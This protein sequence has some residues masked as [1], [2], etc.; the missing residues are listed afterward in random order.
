MGVLASITEPGNAAE[1]GLTQEQLD[2]LEALIKQHESQALTFASEIRRLPSAERRAKESENIRLIERKGL[3]L[4]TAAQQ[5][6]AEMWRLQKLGPA[7]LVEPEVA[8]LMGVSEEQIS[9]IKNILEGKRILLSQMGATKGA[10]ELNSRIVAVLDD[11]QKT[12]WQTVVG[13]PLQNDSKNEADSSPE[14]AVA[15]TAQSPSDVAAKPLLPMTG[16]ENGLVISFNGTPW[17]EVLQWLAKQAELS[18]QVDAYPTGTFTYRDPFRR[19]SVA[20]TMDIMN[21]VLLGKGY[22]LIKKQRILMSQDLGSGDTAATAELTR[23]LVRELAEL[24]PTAELDKRGDYEIVKCVFTIERSVDEIVKEVKDLIGPQGSVVP[25]PTAGQI[26]V[27]ETG[28]KLRIIR[29]LI[30]KSKSAKIVAIPLKHVSPEEVLGLARP[31]LGLKDSVNTS[32]DLSISP[33]SFNNR[34]LATGSADKLQKLSE[35]AAQIDVA[36]SGDAATATAVEPA[37][38][39][40]HRLLGSDPTTTMDVLQSTFA[41][42]T[43][44]KLSS[45]PKTSNILALAI[46]ADHD[47]IDEIIKELAGQNS[48]FEVIQLTRLDTQSAL[49]LLEKFYGKPSKDAATAKGPVFSGDAAT[50]RI[51][52]KG[53]D[54][55]IEQIKKLLNT[56]EAASPEPETLLDGMLLLPDKG[57][58]ADK[59]LDQIQM[60][61]EAKK[62]KS[63]FR[64]I[65]PAGDSKG[66]KIG[67]PKKDGRSASEIGPAS[68]FAKFVATQEDENPVRSKRVTAAA[69][70]QSETRFGSSNEIVIRR[71]PNGMVVTSDNQEAL[72][73][74]NQL[75]K[76]YREQ[77]NNAATEPTVRVLTHIKAAAA[78]ELIQNIIKGEAATGGGGGGGLIGDVASSV[79]GGGGIFGSLFGG[80][81]AGSSGASST[82]TGAAATGNIVLT[83]DPRLNALWIQANAT[84]MQMVEE[85]IEL[86][87]IADS[88]VDN[89]TRGTPGIIF[90]ENVAVADVETLVK[91][92]FA[93]R[94]AQPATG[95]AQGQ[96]SQQDFFALIAGGR[97]G[98]GGGGGGSAKSELKELTMTVSADKKNN[99]LIVVASPML[100]GE[101]EEFVKKIDQA[102]KDDES[103]FIV[104]P[105]PA[106]VNATTMQNALKSAFGAS[107]KTST[108]SP[109]TPGAG[110]AGAPGAAGSPSDFLQ[111]F[112]NRGAGGGG[113]GGFGGFGGGGQGG[114]GGVGQGGFG[115]AGRGGAQGGGGFG[116]GGFGGG[117]RGGAGGGGGGQGGGGRGGR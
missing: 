95:G 90:I 21:S 65:L 23:T 91:Q 30:E 22:T 79:L 85:L 39:R 4:L 11:S 54:Q 31:L 8:K 81:G 69:T 27:C 13:K 41:G 106:E 46:K 60:F 64:V 44:M 103:D 25:L 1:L 73:E 28:G 114:F 100:F 97:G 53:T 87:D 66:N 49:L 6:T 104:V 55:E 77:M 70:T 93:D 92:V 99:A 110:T 19:Y 26:L 80:G 117:Q 61:M 71:G 12:I 102:S 18:L 57:R 29:E 5:S 38:F 115:G 32:E 84:D 14:N 72:K 52:V 62:S 45:D 2:R 50:R 107:V 101:V 16:P 74:F 68:P 20:E 17:K 89:L 88:G 43:N 63:H 37:A 47:K 76:L 82:I 109:T 98:R 15:P 113:A 34:I 111:Q 75:Y 33:D 3:A 48:G 35:I 59:M 36:P 112:R 94:I 96:P 42:Q 116:G 58:A 24:V 105:I 9:K 56:Y 108:A 51:T 7:A 40:S 67:A 86:I 10:A 78:A 83:P